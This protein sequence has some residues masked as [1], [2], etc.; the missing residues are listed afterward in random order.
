MLTSWRPFAAAILLLWPALDPSAAQSPPFTDPREAIEKAEHL[1]DIYNWY[2]A[3][4]YYVEAERMFLAQGD[5]RNALFARASRLRGEM[6]ILPFPDLIDDIDNILATDIAKNDPALRLRCLIIRG[7]VNLEID[8]PAAKDDW[9]IALAT[10]K[11]IGDRK[12]ESRAIGELGMIA[13]LLGDTST[14][15]L[16]VGQALTTAMT[17]GDVG[18]Q[19]RYYAAI[20]TGLQLSQE[21]EQAIRYF[22]LALNTAAKHPE[23]G[24]QYISYWGKAKS[25]LALKRFQEAEQLIRESLQ[26]AEADDR[27]VKKVQMLLAASDLARTLGKPDDALAYLRE[28]LPIAETGGFRRLLAEVYFD[29]A[30]IVQ[31]AGKIAKAGEYASRAVTLSEEV[32]DRFLLPSQLLVL[33]NLKRAEGRPDEALQILER[34]TDVVEGLLVN[35]PTPEH[36]TTLIRA[37]SNI[38]VNHF[39]LAARQKSV[40]YAFSVLERTRGRV[41]R[42]VIAQVAASELNRRRSEEY[43]RLL[44]DLSHLQRSLLTLKRT[45]ER[46]TALQQIWEVEQKLVGAEVETRTWK[47]PR[48]Q[49]VSLRDLRAN[50]GT[51][52]LVVEYVW[53]EDRVYA[54][55]IS[56]DGA[57]VTPL[58]ERGPVERLIAEYFKALQRAADG[59]TT[60]DKLAT[61]LYRAIVAPLRWPASKTKIVIVP[62]GPLHVLPFDMLVAPNRSKLAQTAAITF[63]P[64]ASVLRSLRNREIATKPLPLLAVGDVPYGDISK[65]RNPSRANSIFDARVTPHL[66]GC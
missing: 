48:S 25:L 13:F 12:W 11:Q 61:S 35:V 3:H 50:L 51:N 36:A 63:A 66:A 52:E 27:R 46:E 23:A 18:A 64:S 17:S 26:H 10:A 33:A 62:D 16:Q 60:V 2:D 6:Q 57:R 58:A 42:D 39:E 34:A 29:L 59:P 31:Q 15:R 55:T 8:A 4:P 43:I 54:M 20:A 30:A 24:F 49:A 41:L 21:Y 5:E 9:E 19:I 28:A 45:T 53:G 44:R 22:D 65:R 56:R 37:M 14:A 7:D 40:D 38:Y 1:V 32:G 47:G